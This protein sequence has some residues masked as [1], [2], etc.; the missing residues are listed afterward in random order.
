M[1]RERRD[2]IELFMHRRIGLLVKSVASDRKL[3]GYGTP[4]TLDYS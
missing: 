1:W 4:Q 2:L 3:I